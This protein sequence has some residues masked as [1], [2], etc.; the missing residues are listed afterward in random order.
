[1]GGRSTDVSTAR[2]LVFVTKANA[3]LPAGCRGLLVGTAGACNIMDSDGVSHVN[4]PL[5]QGYNYI[6]VKQVQTGGTSSADNI[7]ALY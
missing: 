7:W 5:Q 4:V 3:D 6:Q 1:M 2:K